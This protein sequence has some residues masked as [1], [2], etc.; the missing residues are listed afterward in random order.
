M[1][2]LSQRVP[3]TQILKQIRVFMSIKKRPDGPIKSPLP[4]AQNYLNKNILK[5]Q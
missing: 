4:V 5:M 2:L 3:V 1:G